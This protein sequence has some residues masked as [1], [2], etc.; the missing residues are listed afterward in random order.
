MRRALDVWPDMARGDFGRAM[1]S[2]HEKT[3]HSPQ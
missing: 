1:M 3:P 2:L